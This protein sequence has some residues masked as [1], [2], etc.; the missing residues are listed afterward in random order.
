L[1]VGLNCVRPARVTAALPVLREAGVL[2]IAAYANAGEGFG[3]TGWCGVRAS[4]EAFAEHARVWVAAG[5]T[6]VGGCCRTT[7]AHIEALRRT[8]CSA[9]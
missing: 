1:G 2:E 6:I 8:L 9:S 4:P 3:P 7:P 5:A